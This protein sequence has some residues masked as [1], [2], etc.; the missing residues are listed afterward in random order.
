MKFKAVFAIFNLIVVISFLLIFFL[1]LIMFDA[2]LALSFWESSWG[3]FVLFIL[4]LVSV[5]VYV[6][7]NA[8]MFRL[9]EQEDWRGL[10]TWLFETRLEKG[11]FTSQ[12]LLLFLN[13]SLM[14]NDLAAIDRVR[15]MCETK[16]PALARRHRVPL[17]ISIVLRSDPD[18]MA[19]RF[20]P[21]GI[22]RDDNWYT[23]FCS[24]AHILKNRGDDAKALLLSLAS[25]KGLEPTLALLVMYFLKNFESDIEVRD[26]IEAY[27][28]GICK[29][30]TRQEF[31]DRAQ[32][33]RESSLSLILSKFVKEAAAWAF[34]GETRQELQSGQGGPQ[35]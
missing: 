6:I 17:S 16:A 1:P 32:R 23:W 3:L 33:A 28:S 27:R 30:Y 5:N 31:A 20:D 11:I 2:E 22:S 24:Y 18:E 34:D 14:L 15:T 35:R 9:I 10:A 21:A 29:R 8:K 12:Y 7:A 25:E 4:I 19:G 26:R 13:C